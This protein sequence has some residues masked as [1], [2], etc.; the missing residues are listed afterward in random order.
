MKINLTKHFGR[1]LVD[2]D[3]E[4]Y[5]MSNR[6]NFLKPRETIHVDVIF[7]SDISLCGLY[8]AIFV[9]YLSLAPE[10]GFHIFIMKILWKLC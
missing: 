9:G 10:V 1:E 7:N 2:Q 8:D 3:N 5:L 4:I 6:K